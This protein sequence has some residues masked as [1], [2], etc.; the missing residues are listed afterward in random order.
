M[1]SP[2]RS[3]AIC[4]SASS[5]NRKISIP[6]EP[7]K[8]LMSAMALDTWE[9]TKFNLSSSMTRLPQFI[10]ICIKKGKRDST[11]RVA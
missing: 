11:T 7:N 2:L 5:Q 9:I 6:G 10:E 4:F 1:A 8:K 3:R